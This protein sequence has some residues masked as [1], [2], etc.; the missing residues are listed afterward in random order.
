MQPGDVAA[1]A[2]AIERLLADPG[3][4]FAMGRAG[5]EKVERDFSPTVHLERLAV[6][7]DEAR[8]RAGRLP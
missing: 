5:R 1:L 8:A 2:E 3:R 6:I 7:Y 4:A